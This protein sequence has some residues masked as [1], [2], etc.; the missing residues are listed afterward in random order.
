[1]TSDPWGPIRPELWSTVP[2][3]RDRPATEWDVHGGIAVFYMGNDSQ[4]ALPMTLP[5]PAFH[6]D[7]ETGRM[8]PVVVIQAESAGDQHIVGLRFLT[9][10]HGVCLMDELVFVE[11][12]DIPEWISTASRA[13]DPAALDEPLDSTPLESG[14]ADSSMT[15]V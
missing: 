15:N 7:A 6:V 11:E 9:G 14:A 10:G 8:T 1:M 3:I 4:E 5:Q 12:R 13:L 2:A